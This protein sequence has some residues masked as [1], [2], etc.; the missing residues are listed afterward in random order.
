MYDFLIDLRINAFVRI[1]LQVAKP[2]LIITHVKGLPN[3]FSFSDPRNML[4]ESHDRI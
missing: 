2:D 1:A 4:P 3:A